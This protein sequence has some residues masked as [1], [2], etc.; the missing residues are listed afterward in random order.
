MAALAISAI[1]GTVWIAT[2]RFELPEPTGN[3]A[4]GR[5]HEAFGDERRIAATIYY[6]AVHGTG[7]VGPFAHIPDPWGR[8]RHHARDAADWAPGRHPLVLFSPGADV[9]PQYYNA[10]L[11]ELASHGYVVAALSHPGL[12]PWIAYPDAAAVSSTGPTM[13]STAGEAMQQHEARI[14]TVAHDIASARAHLEALLGD[15][16]D[17]RVAAFG[18][19]LGGAGAVAAAVRNP[20]IGVVGDLDGSLGATARGVAMDRPVFFMADDGEVPSADQA[21]RASFVRGGAP[22]LKVTLHG[23]SHMTFATD[24]NFFEEAVPL[25]DG[26]DLGA[27]E[28]HR[29]IAKPLVAFFAANLA[30]AA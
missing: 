10:L 21:A 24:V 18:H 27:L 3:H 1:L 14:T 26:D 16:L 23:A 4:V 30:V 2:A 20:A 13:P 12:T 5:S 15:H 28:A 17:G 6:P 29:D 9:Q 22:G 11:S 7:D 25:M 19:S 8:V